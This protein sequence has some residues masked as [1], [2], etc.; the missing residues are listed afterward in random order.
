MENKRIYFLDSLRGIAAVI[1]VLTHICNV[2]MKDSNIKFSFLS[3]GRSS[4]ILF[5]ILSGLVL[6]Q[7]LSNSKESDNYLS[8]AFKRFKRI[9]LPF[10][11]SMIIIE[12]SYFLIR[13]T[14]IVGLGSW[15]NQIG[16]NYGNS[17]VI[18]N[19]I[20]MTGN[21]VEDINPVI[22]SL[23]I[24]LRISFVFPLIYLLIKKSSIKLSIVIASFCFCI[25]TF[26]L[27]LF[28]QVFLIGQTIFHIGFFVFGV[29]IYLNQSYLIQLKER[30]KKVFFYIS[31]ILYLNQSILNLFNYYL[32][33]T[34]SDILTGL[35]GVGIIL[36]LFSSRKMQ[37]KLCNTYFLWLGKISFSL[38]LYHCIIFISFIYLFQY[39][40]IP[41]I[42]SLFFSIPSIFICAHIAFKSIEEPS[43][44]WFK[45]NKLNK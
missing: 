18:L 37:I 14:G 7:N 2:F 4:V 3:L 45:F 24:E 12:F 38:Y 11:L 31:L 1:V 28:N 36:I 34:I 8:F 40:N 32:M 19:N 16:I 33:Q 9:Y 43:K 13:P 30:E 22:W 5:F 25:G 23:I 44:Y 10:I 17:N 29:F 35:G 21:N 41:I 39:Y 27:I 42:F 20:V 15:F 6:S 26:I